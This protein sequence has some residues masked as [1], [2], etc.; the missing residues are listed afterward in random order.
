M[1]VAIPWTCHY[2]PPPAHPFF[3]SAGLKPVQEVTELHER[4]TSGSHPWYTS[5]S[6]FLV[7]LL[8]PMNTF[9]L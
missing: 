7:S 3:D 8:Q 4:K 2:R 6:W 5:A 1:A 9:M